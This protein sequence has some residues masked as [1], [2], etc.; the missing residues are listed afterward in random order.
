MHMEI[1]S[2]SPYI[3]EWLANHLSQGSSYRE[4]KSDAVKVR[5]IVDVPSL[6]AL[7]T[8]VNMVDLPEHIAI[9]TPLSNK[10]YSECL[11]SMGAATV[12]SLLTPPNELIEALAATTS[13]D[14]RSLSILTPKE[15]Q[16]LSLLLL[17][18][19]GTDI[20]RHLKI[21]NST[22]NSHMSNILQKAMLPNR[23][24]LIAS[25]ITPL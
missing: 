18:F 6:W 24:V 16:V 7:E 9:A 15:Y 17:G 21:K 25:I 5:V 3:K 2:S 19:S 12:V 20:A 10:L 4:S 11:L 22:V 14:V 13:R 23:S 8:I 1:Y